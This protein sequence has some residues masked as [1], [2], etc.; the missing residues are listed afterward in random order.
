MQHLS[1]SLE[2]T[3]QIATDFATKLRGG[4]FIALEGEVGSGKTT[5]VQGI[6]SALG[7]SET[8]TSPTFAIMNIYHGECQIVHLDLYR[9]KTVSE[10][11]ALG[12][13]EYL[14][15]PNTIV[16]AEWPHAVDGVDWKPSQTIRFTT[17]SETDRTIEII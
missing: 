14:G 10:I 6:C 8:V 1:S 7:V 13:E 5:F 2:Q 17:T 4:E 11:R 3:K 9:L 12:L 15:Q 16:L